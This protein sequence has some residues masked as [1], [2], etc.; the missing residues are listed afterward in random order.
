MGGWAMSFR[1]MKA[2]LLACSGIAALIAATADANAGGLAVH[3]QSAYG[4]GSS[5]AG[6][7]A[8]GALSSMFYNPATL[9]QV[10]GMQSESVMTGILPSTTNSATGSNVPALAALGGTGNI[11]HSAL[12]PS[13]YFSYQFNQQLWLGLSINAPFGLAET[14]PDSWTGRVYAA[15][16][17]HLGTYNFAPTVAYK[18][19]D[20]ISIGF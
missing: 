4:Q 13:S 9:T 6:V 18:F 7:A 11:A 8:G 12:V 15:G 1:G 5:F 19:S 3:E 14:F 17:D 2:V 16:G 20:L 10:P